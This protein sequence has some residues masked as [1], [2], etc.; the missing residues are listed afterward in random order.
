[1]AR[2][3]RDELSEAR[4]KVNVLGQSLPLDLQRQLL[5]ITIRCYAM[6]VQPSDSVPLRSAGA[7]LRSLMGVADISESERQVLALVMASII[8][9]NDAIEHVHEVHSATEELEDRAASVRLLMKVTT[10]ELPSR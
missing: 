6:A 9:A 3:P 2:I 4:H 7:L 5:S 8:R 10:G 1:M